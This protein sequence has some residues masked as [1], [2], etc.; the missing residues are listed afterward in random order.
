MQRH[1]LN[2]RVVIAASNLLYQA[3]VQSLIKHIGVQPEYIIL[4]SIKNNEITPHAGA[5][6]LIFDHKMLSKPKAKHFQQIN[7]LFKGKILVI[8]SEKTSPDFHTHIILP[9]DSKSTVVE[10]IQNFFTLQNIKDK[11]ENE[12][13]LSTREI[14]VLQKVAKGLSN[15][16]ISEQLFISINTVITHRKNITEKLGIKTISGLTVYALMNSMINPEEITA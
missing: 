4:K 1:K 6:Y 5:D 10:K 7:S 3:G 8:G 15:K 13:I 14:E 9:S 11:S 16:E 12:G 2:T